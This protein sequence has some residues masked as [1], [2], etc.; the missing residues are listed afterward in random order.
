MEIDLERFNAFSSD[1]WAH[2]LTHLTSGQPGTPPL[3]RYAARELDQDIVSLF[4]QL[5]L[6]SAERFRTGLRKALQ[7]VPLFP[8]YARSLFW[9]LQVVSALKAPGAL[10]YLDQAIRGEALRGIRF[11]KETLH[12]VA[13][14]ARAKFGVTADFVT[15][16]IDS[17]HRSRSTIMLCWS[18]A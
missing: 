14:N 17:A 6:A 2:W 8:V 15:Y 18:F 11:A 7:D 1:E 5:P 16:L 12:A 9:L 3:R 13:L 10:P 4:R